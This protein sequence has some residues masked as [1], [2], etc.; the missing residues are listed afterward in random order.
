[1]RLI[2]FVLPD[3]WF[4]VNTPAHTEHD[5][6]QC[7]CASKVLGGL[8]FLINSDPVKV[9][10]KSPISEQ[11]FSSDLTTH[12]KTSFH[13]KE[14]TV[15]VVKSHPMTAQRGIILDSICLLVGWMQLQM[16][17][18]RSQR[19]VWLSGVDRYILWNQSW[20]RLWLPKSTWKSTESVKCNTEWKYQIYE[21]KAQCRIT[22]C[23]SRWHTD[24]LLG[25]NM[26]MISTSLSLFGCS[27]SAQCSNSGTVYL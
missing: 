2:Y 27:P 21:S 22:Y 13:E 1:M 8:I 14:L 10:H 15:Q 26:E 9:S 6:C 17:R 7:N 12:D 25:P 18:I 20:Y 16:K 19:S 3:Y 4:K 11:D 5:F 23:S 24:N